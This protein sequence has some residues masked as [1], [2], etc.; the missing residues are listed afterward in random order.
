MA[1]K[2]QLS[3]MSLEVG[4]LAQRLEKIVEMGD[5]GIKNMVSDMNQKHGV[6]HD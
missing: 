2:N 3:S 1:E 5:D 4:M 6:R